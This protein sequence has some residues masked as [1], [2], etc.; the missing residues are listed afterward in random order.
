MIKSCLT[1]AWASTS[2]LA[3]ITFSIVVLAPFRA[4]IKSI[5][6]GQWL[7][8]PSR[9]IR[10]G[11]SET[12]FLVCSNFAQQQGIRFGGNAG[13]R[14][15]LFPDLI[16]GFRL[17]LW[18]GGMYGRHGQSKQNGRDGFHD[19]IS[20]GQMDNGCHRISNAS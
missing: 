9:T 8:T 3:S 11:R 12:A 16:A 6:L 1:G 18:G 13:M 17:D 5:V 2:L 15:N 19:F 14:L 7:V 4:T 10:L 20:F